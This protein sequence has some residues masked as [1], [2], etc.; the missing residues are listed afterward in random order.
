M[1]RRLAA[2]HLGLE[3]D[4]LRFYE[5]HEIDSPGAF[6]S[7]FRRRLDELTLDDTERHQVVDEAREAFRLNGAI[8]AQLVAE[9][10]S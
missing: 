2:Q 1:L 7:D 10:G 5:F 8:F 9:D 4:G 3:H 6:K